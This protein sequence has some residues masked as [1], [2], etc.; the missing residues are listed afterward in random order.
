[1][2]ETIWFHGKS[3]C[4]YKS[5]LVYC[6]AIIYTDRHLYYTYMICHILSAVYIYLRSII[7]IH[8]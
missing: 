5:C 3:L 2:S 8:L 1:M 7:I 4:L 6:T